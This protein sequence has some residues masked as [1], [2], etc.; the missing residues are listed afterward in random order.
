MKLKREKKASNKYITILEQ[1]M[2]YEVCMCFVCI[3]F[4][5]DGSN[6]ELRIQFEREKNKEQEKHLCRTTAL[7]ALP[8]AYGIRFASNFQNVKYMYYIMHWQRR[9]TD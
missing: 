2:F 3:S 8:N 4:K 5:R 6:V 1:Y 9:P 7:N